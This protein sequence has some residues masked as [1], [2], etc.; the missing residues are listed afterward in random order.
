MVVVV[1]GCNLHP[2]ELVPA[3]PWRSQTLEL[4]A[5]ALDARIRRMC[6]PT[7]RFCASS[8]T[9]SWQSGA[10]NVEHSVWTTAFTMVLG[11]TSQSTHVRSPTAVASEPDDDDEEEEAAAECG[12]EAMAARAQSARERRK[13]LGRTIPSCRRLEGELACAREGEWGN[14]LK[15]NWADG[16]GSQRTERH[17]IFKRPR[18][19]RGGIRLVP[20]ETNRRYCFRLFMFPS[21]PLS[22]NRTLCFR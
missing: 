8:Q 17:K 12:P 3:P 11:I 2:A 15:L 20:T 16:C 13:W 22:F 21:N 14:E 10:V 7:V 5:T 6:T 9:P 1:V 19:S 4:D 18:I